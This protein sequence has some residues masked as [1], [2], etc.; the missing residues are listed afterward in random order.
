VGFTYDQWRHKIV[1]EVEKSLGVQ[2][3]TWVDD[4]LPPEAMLK[5]DKVFEAVKR[6]LWELSNLHKT[7]WAPA[8]INFSPA[9]EMSLNFLLGIIDQIKT[10]RAINAGFPGNQEQEYF[11]WGFFDPKQE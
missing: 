10:G 4:D 11:D 1:L 3:K 5:M 2:G 7:A 9:M 6:K 8:L